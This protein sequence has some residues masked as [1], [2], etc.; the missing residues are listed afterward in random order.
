MI[1]IIILYNYYILQC[2]TKNILCKRNIN[3]LQIHIGVG[4]VE[5]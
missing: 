4:E 2:I 3:I 1:K 5:N